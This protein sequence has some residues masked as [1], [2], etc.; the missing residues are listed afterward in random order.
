MQQIEV[1]RGISEFGLLAVTAAFFLIFSAS[2]MVIFVKWFVKIINGIIDGQKDVMNE[3]LSETQKQNES[4]NDIREGL[5]TETTS[6]VKVI[7]SLVFDLSVER[8][9]QMILKIKEEN[10]IE[11]REMVRRKITSFV[12]N[13]FDDRNSKLDNFKFRGKKLGEYTNIVWIEWTSE[14]MEKEIYDDHPS[15]SRTHTNV[16]LNYERIKIDFYKR[17]RTN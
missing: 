11:D 8:V 1:A 4:L 17:L 3:L 5:I 2:M 13:M 6:R 12:Q 7:S 10:H 16:V 15:T 9:R 14:L